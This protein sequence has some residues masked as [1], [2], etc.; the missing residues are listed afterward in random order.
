MEEWALG[1][2]A[3]EGVRTVDGARCPVV[4]GKQNQSSFLPYS[5]APC[6]EGLRPGC[7]FS[8]RVIKRIKTR[9]LFPSDSLM[10]SILLSLIVCLVCSFLF[11][12]SFICSFIGSINASEY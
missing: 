3:L 10:D 4:E 1:G 11:L 9:I 12:G 6:S 8:S 2:E 5:T 7:W